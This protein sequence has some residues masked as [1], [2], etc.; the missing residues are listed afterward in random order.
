[1]D[2]PHSKYFHDQA[3]LCVRL[4]RGSIDRGLVQKLTDMAPEYQDK[5]EQLNRDEPAPQRG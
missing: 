2:Q 3:E 5:A 1:M 4:A